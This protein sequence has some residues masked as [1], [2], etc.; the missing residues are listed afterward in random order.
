MFGHRYFGARW[1]GPR[2]WGDGSNTPPPVAA[3]LFFEADL[4]THLSADATIVALAASRIY[5][6]LLPQGARLP[7]VVYSVPV[8][9]EQGNLPGHSGDVEHYRLQVDCWALTDAASDA[10]AAAVR[11]RMRTAADTFRAVMLESAFE[12]FEPETRRHRRL[13]E[14]SVWYDVP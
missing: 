2:Y 9:E 12:D 13:L 7:A 4:F 14:F 10:L 1:F 8:L 11:A 5:P 6:V 3:G